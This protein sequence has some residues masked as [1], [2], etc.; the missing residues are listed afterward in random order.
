MLLD[1]IHYQEHLKKTQPDADSRW[2]NVQ[3]LI[4]F[5]RESETNGS[6]NQILTT[7]D[8]D[9]EWDDQQEDFDHAAFEEDGIV[10][11]KSAAARGNAST[12]RYD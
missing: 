1:L 3:E 9:D 7:S 5:A 10:E 12:K 2:D 6:C 11:M 4:T 8:A